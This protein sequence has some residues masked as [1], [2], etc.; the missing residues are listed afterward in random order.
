MQRRLLLRHPQ[1]VIP[2]DRRGRY[3]HFR[4][5]TKTP[6]GLTGYLRE[7]GIRKVFVTGLATDFCVA[8]T[9]IDAR[10]NG[11]EAQRNKKTPRAPST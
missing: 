9:A 10:K 11:F 1:R 6:S 8:W 7:R 3:L 2:D 5:P 4:K